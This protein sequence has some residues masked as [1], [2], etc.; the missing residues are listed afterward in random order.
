M[1]GGGAK[2]DL[3]C[4]DDYDLAAAIARCPVPVFTA[5]G[6]DQDYHVCDMVAY[7]YLKTPTA[8]A[9][10]LIGYYVDED[11]RLLS[12]ASRLKLAFQNKIARMENAL[13]LL[14]TRIR[15]SDPRTILQ[16]GY[17]LALDASGV[18]FKRAAGR[19]RGEMVSMM[20]ADGT[21]DCE[22]RDVMQVLPDIKEEIKRGDTQ[23][24]KRFRRN[25]YIVILW[26]ER[27]RQQMTEPVSTMPVLWR[28]L[29]R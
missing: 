1:R 27:K 15:T 29:R 22:V 10:E 24:E 4:Y 25:R 13:Q 16:R 11:A 26:Q 23:K 21:V 17:V 12:Y 8:L 14:E 3:A 5:V 6:H 28:S 18:P 7:H 19:V 2:L 20:F 9:D